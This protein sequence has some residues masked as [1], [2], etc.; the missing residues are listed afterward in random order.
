MLDDEIVLVIQFINSKNGSR[1]PAFQLTQQQ[2]KD[3]I[4]EHFNDEQKEEQLILLLMSSNDEEF[5]AKPLITCNQ[6]LG[7]INNG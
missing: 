1:S 4:I 2:I 7:V 5:S 3:F 6:F